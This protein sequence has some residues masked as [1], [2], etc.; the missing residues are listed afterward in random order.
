MD[1]QQL[2]LEPLIAPPAVSWWPLAPIWWLG[3]G[4]LILLIIAVVI[5]RYTK[6]LTPKQPSLP[7][8]DFD[9]RRQAALNE[10]SNLTKPYQQKAGVWLQQ[11]ND[12]LKRIA[13]IR[14]PTENPQALI[15]QAWLTFLNSKCPSAQI[16][17]FP[18]LVEGEYHPNYYMDNK[19]IDEL[20]LSVEQWIT[21]HV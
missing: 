16:K 14:Y 1:P 17:L 10:L 6:K 13:I 8:I 2:P 19:T 18:M 3:L 4:L 9:L 21:D 5:Y 15:G 12:L 11:L 7:T 20:Y